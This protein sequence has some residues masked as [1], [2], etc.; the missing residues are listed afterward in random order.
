MNQLKF[1][2]SLLKR[3]AV[4][5][6]AVAVFSVFFLPGQAAAFNGGVGAGV[7]VPN[8]DMAKHFN[9]GYDLYA[10][11][12]FNIIPT[13]FDI[14]L[15]GDWYHATGKSGS[16]DVVNRTYNADS[17]F[18]ALGYEAIAV[19]APTLFPIVKPY[20]GV[21]WGFY[22]STFE[23]RGYSETKSGNGA[24]GIAGVGIN[25]LIVRISLDGKYFT[26]TI[27]NEDFGGY[28]VGLSASIYF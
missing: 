9:P 5:I 27:D 28:R 12:S 13:L 21:G 23:V 19:L 24:V 2:I 7:F 11:A 10:Y 1:K 26:N 25:V 20:A 14:R 6:S 18:S 8:S 22:T 4:I 17:K 15:Q 3:L 16:V